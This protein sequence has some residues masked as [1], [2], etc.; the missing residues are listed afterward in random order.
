MNPDLRAFIAYNA[1]CHR[2]SLV[3]YRGIMRKCG[4]KALKVW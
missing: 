2:M 3:I 1:L 4:V